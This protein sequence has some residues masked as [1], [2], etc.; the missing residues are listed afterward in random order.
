MAIFPAGESISIEEIIE[1]KNYF[2]NYIL[3]FVK[4]D[5]IHKNIISNKNKSFIIH[6]ITEKVKTI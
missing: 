4:I 1:A 2:Y 5:S 6:N 3:S